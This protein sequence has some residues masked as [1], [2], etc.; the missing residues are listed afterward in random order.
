MHGLDKL[1]AAGLIPQHLPQLPNR[2]RQDRLTHRRLGPHGSKQGLFGQQLSHLCHQGV[3]H[4]EGFVAHGQDVVPTPQAL[5]VHVKAEGSEAKAGR[6]LHRS[7]CAWEA[8]V[9]MFKSG[10][11]F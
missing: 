2:H 8:E 11:K 7:P 4:P 6:F 9:G 3:Q 5:V 1:R 10:S